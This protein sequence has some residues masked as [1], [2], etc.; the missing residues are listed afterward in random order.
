MK[1]EAVQ[2]GSGGPPAQRNLQSR[3]R[4]MV[5]FRKTGIHACNKKCLDLLDYMHSVTA[6]KFS[7]A[8]FT[9]KMTFFVDN[10][11]HPILDT[12][13]SCFSEKLIS[14][15]CYLYCA[16][17][18]NHRKWLYWMTSFSFLHH[19]NW[20]FPQNFFCVVSDSW[21]IACSNLAWYLLIKGF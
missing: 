7:S 14:T 17:Y 9:R 13:L 8:D 5:N 11:R 10:G 19:L 1:A 18:C 15:L 16:Y 21:E 12:L 20:S 2:I 3:K 4:S 6:V